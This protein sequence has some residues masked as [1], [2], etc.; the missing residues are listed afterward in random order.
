[1]KRIA[2]IL[3]L[4]LLASVAVRAETDPL[5]DA[6]TGKLQCYAPDAAR[7][8][9]KALAA[10]VFGADGTITN[11]A[12]VL[13]AP[14]PII[15]MHVNAPV[16]VRDG[17]ICG[18]A[19]AEDIDSSSIEVAGHPATPE[20]EGPI[21]ARIKTSIEPR[22]GKEICT[23]YLPSGDHLTAQVTVD[24]T[25][26]PQMAAAVIWVGREEGYRVSP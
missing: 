8:T 12:V 24:G 11:P 21:K 18:V 19:R 15:L 16:A 14:Q 23:S 10:Y 26:Q 9:C 3:G 13:V 4:S 1:M 5:A 22:M 7:K 17:A 6:R 2:A 20:E 25:L